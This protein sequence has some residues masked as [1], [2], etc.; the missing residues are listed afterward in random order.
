[1]VVSSQQNVFKQ[2]IHNTDTALRNWYKLQKRNILL[3]KV[4]TL[5]FTFKNCELNTLVERNMRFITL[6]ICD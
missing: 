1:M 6:M 3:S 2:R 4:C 5:Q